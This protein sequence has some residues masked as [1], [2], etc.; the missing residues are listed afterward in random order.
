MRLPHRSVP[1][2]EDRPLLQFDR[3]ECLRLDTTLSRVWLETDGRGGYAASTPLLAPTSRFHGLLNVPFD[4]ESERH[5]LLA[6]L[7]ESVHAD[8]RGFPLSAVRYSGSGAGAVFSPEGHKF[9]EEFEA[10]PHPATT[11]R[12]GAA[13]IRRE[14]RMVRGEPG[15]PRAVQVRY[16]LEGRDAPIELR[17]RPFVTARRADSLTFRNDALDTTV[18]RDGA[19]VLVRPYASLPELALRVDGAQADFHEGGDWYLGLEYDDDLARGY[20]GHEDQWT[21]G[22]FRVELRPGQD[23]LLTASVEGVVA[24]PDRAWA[25]HPGRATPDTEDV[26]LHRALERAA[27]HYLVRTETGVDGATRLGV[28]AGYPWFGEWGRDTFIALP[29]LTLARGDLERCGEVLV[30]ALPFVRDGR[31]ANV[32]GPSGEFSDYRAVDA[33]FWFARAIR[34]YDEELRHVGAR[35]DRLLDELAPALEELLRWHRTADTELVSV[36]PDGLLRAGSEHV[37]TTW[38]D[39]VVADVPVTPRDGLQVEVNALWFQALH[40]LADLL[41]ELARPDDAADWRAFADRVGIAFRERFWLADRER[42]ADRVVF[43]PDGTATPDTA[44]RPNMVIAAALEPSPLTTDQRRAVVEVSRKELLTPWGLRTL[45]PRHL[46]YRGQY[47]GDVHRRDHAYHQ[48]TVWPW[49]LGF[50]VEAELRAAPPEERSARREELRVRLEAFKPHL[51]EHG[52]GH[53]S[54]VFDGDPPHRPGG[55][56]AQAW[57]V[58]ELLRASFLLEVDA[59]GTGGTT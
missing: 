23:V 24:D 34:L 26:E 46:T 47:A 8:G 6:R 5:Q 44:V 20:D 32:Y 7:E 37:A 9:V 15:T 10:D 50:H 38:M 22:E 40:H 17:V 58:A 59:A 31:L 42:L 56:F 52:L 3:A 14:V 19:D 28:V 55:C 25:A 11:Y 48:G 39:A 18:R 54:E 33:S 53:V 51:R 43:A 41:D 35:R 29:G 57:S 1:G 45:S 49:L 16:H 30:D 21:P 36:Q 4:G 12:M 2:G 13:R 27:E